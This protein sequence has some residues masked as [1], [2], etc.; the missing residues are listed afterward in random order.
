MA[1][2]HAGY[3]HPVLQA[4]RIHRLDELDTEFLIMKPERNVLSISEFF[5]EERALE[6]RKRC[7]GVF[8]I[9]VMRGFTLRG[10]ANSNW[11]RFSIERKAS[12]WRGI[13]ILSWMSFCLPSG[14]QLISEDLDSS[15]GYLGGLL[16]SPWWSSFGHLERVVESLRRS[17]WPSRPPFFLKTIC[18][19]RIRSLG[20]F[21]CMIKL[22]YMPC[23]QKQKCW[24]LERRI[25]LRREILGLGKRICWWWT[26]WVFFHCT[27]LLA[28]M[29]ISPI[30]IRL[31]HQ[32]NQ[33][34]KLKRYTFPQIRARLTWK[35]TTFLANLH[36]ILQSY[37]SL[38]PAFPIWK[39]SS[40][41][42]MRSS[43]CFLRKHNGLL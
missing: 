33:Q 23:Q 24:L 40:W 28:L 19:F 38:S 25:S 3:V 5:K 27:V 1:C 15:D 22:A 17:L 37:N 14:W 4:L 12:A 29:V 13:P 9:V 42:S 31:R 21:V 43:T 20:G 7:Q 6:L 36:F 26:W 10:A 16:R 41:S 34:R 39:T 30:N 32:R 35:L 2:R 18:G 8:L 11:A